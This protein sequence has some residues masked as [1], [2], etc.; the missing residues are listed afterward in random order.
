MSRFS[1]LFLLD[2][3]KTLGFTDKQIFLC[4]FQAKN[5]VFESAGYD[6]GHRNSLIPP[7]IFEVSI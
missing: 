1:S 5:T 6:G 7:V 3:T 2:S 4:I